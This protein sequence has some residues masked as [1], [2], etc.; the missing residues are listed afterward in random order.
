MS[1]LVSNQTI[2]YVGQ[3]PLFLSISA[4]V[5]RMGSNLLISNI[6]LTYSSNASSGTSETV[7]ITTQIEDKA[8][9][10][11]LISDMNTVKSR[12]TNS[13]LVFVVDGSDVH[14]PQTKTFPDIVLPLADSDTSRTLTLMP[15]T[16]F[17]TDFT[18][19]FSARGTVQ[20]DDKVYGYVSNLTDRVDKLYGSSGGVTVP[21]TKL[22]ASVNGETKRVY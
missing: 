18:L 19:T 4:Y 22:Y 12:A 21:I 20:S 10:N 5:A 11:I 17:E 15:G 13:P 16:T 1:T 14:L 6:S 9:S 2:V 3:K 8:T 7:G